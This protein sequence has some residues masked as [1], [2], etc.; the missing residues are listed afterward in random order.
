MKNALLSTGVV[1]RLQVPAKTVMQCVAITLFHNMTL[2]NEITLMSYDEHM[3][4]L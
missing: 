2:S 1:M 4:Y 3:Y